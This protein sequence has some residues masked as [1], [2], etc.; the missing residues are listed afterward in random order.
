MQFDTGN[1]IELAVL[2]MTGVVAFLRL[3][4]RVDTL[5]SDFENHKESHRGLERRVAEHENKVEAKLDAMNGKMD[6]LKDLIIQR[7]EK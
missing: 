1:F 5:R 7:T 3:D 2:F 4:G 6:E